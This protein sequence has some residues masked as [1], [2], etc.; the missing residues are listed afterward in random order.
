M[1]QREAVILTIEKLGGIATLGQ[2]Y[3]E[4]L[5]IKECIWR[6][7]TPFASIRKIVQEYKVSEAK[8]EIYKIK[9]GL[10]SLIKFKKANEENGIF[11]E[12]E[13]N[14]N[15]KEMEIFNHSYYQG[16]LLNLGNLRNF[17][18]FCPNQD[19][20]KKFIDKTSLGNLRTLNNIPN[21]S[22]PELVK[23][24][25]TIDV[26]WFNYGFMELRM[27]D[28][29]FEIEHST[30]IQNSLLKFNDLRN[31]YTRMIIIADKSREEEFKTKIEY[32]AFQNLKERVKFLNYDE[33]VKQYEKT[34]EIL[35]CNVIL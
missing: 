30:D 19:K 5:K 34:I 21:F 12:T 7:K 14:K 6:T 23:R 10:Y 28:S 29:F 3:Q 13:K 22:Y 27:P 16:L 26:I 24:S 15:S 31:F 11:E 4:V 32:Q 1:T 18:T 20:N 8:K 9:P 17:D 25:S 33:L 35:N 2:L